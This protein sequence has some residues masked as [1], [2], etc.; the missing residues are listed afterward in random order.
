MA[1][2]TAAIVRPSEDRG[3]II[4]AGVCAVIAFGGF[5]GTYW[6]QVPAGTFV[7]SPLL[8]LHG[9]LFSIWTLFFLS[10]AALIATGRYASHR[11]WGLFG[12]ALATAM[13]FTGAAVAIGGMQDRIAHGL[14]EAGRAFVIVPM[15]A[16]S[17][18]A[19]FITAA[20]VNRRRRDWHKR[21]MLVAT[22]SLLNAP[23]AR[24]FFLYA[25]G[26]GPGLRPGLGPPRPAE[27]A[28]TAGLL[29]DGVIVLAMLFDWRS[30]GRPHPAYLWGLGV[31]FAVQELRGP[32]S[33]TAAWSAVAD[34]LARF[35][36]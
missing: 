23:I 35:A 8:H 11:A 26:G 12:V 25:T 30:R 1:T 13:V 33:H 3:F 17:L 21:L 36:G 32:V 2:A 27:F 34:F 14:G 6:L 15:S 7:G 24:F 9:L 31:T 28:L 20:M 22:A 16:I 4:L 5:A 10:Q 18:F 29:A 19:I